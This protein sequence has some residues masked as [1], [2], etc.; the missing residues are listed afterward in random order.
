MEKPKLTAIEGGR[1][2]PPGP[3][4]HGGPTRHHLA[5]L[6]IEVLRALPRGDDRR[7]RL[8]TEL[9][10]VCQHFPLIDPTT[11]I[12]AITG[13]VARELHDKIA[14]CGDPVLAGA[15]ELEHIVFLALRL[16]AEACAK[17]PAAEG[18]ASTVRR[19]LVSA[20]ERFSPGRRTRR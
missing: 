16:A 13:P 19:H 14:R 3:P 12:G 20:I 17:D 4:D 15:G 9:D 10:E 6:I 2:G 7:A 1:R 8:W 5:K 11:P 18:R